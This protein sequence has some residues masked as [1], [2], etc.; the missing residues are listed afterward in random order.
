MQLSV[1]IFS[2]I[3]LFINFFLAEEVCIKLVTTPSQMKD[4]FSP[5][6]L[7]TGILAVLYTNNKLMPRPPSRSQ[8]DKPGIH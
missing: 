4:L 1:N 8:P 5:F 3:S 7:L 2:Q 6:M